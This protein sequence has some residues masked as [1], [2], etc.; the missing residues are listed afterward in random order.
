MS[1]SD[2]LVDA[3][4]AEAHIG[5]AWCRHRRGRRGHQRVR[6]GSHPQRDQDRL[7]EGPAGPGPPRLRRQDRLR[8]AA[9]R[10]GHLQRRHRAA[11]R[12]QQQLVRRLRV[13]VLQAVRPPERPAARRRP[14]EVG[15]RLARADHRRANPRED[16]LHRLRAGR[17]AARAARRGHRRD[18]Q[19]NLVD[20]RSPDEF[21]GR[22]LAP[23]HLPQEQAQRGGHI[24]TARTSRGPRP[25]TR[26]ARSGPTTSSPALPG[27]RRRW[28]SA[29]TP[30]PTAGSASARRTPGSC[31]TSCSACP[32]SRTTTARGP[33]TARWSACRS[34]WVRPDEPT[35]AARP[36][37]GSAITKARPA[38][39]RSSRGR[40][41]RAAPRSPPGT[42]G[43]SAPATSSWPR[44]RWVRRR[45]P[46]LR[47][48]RRRGRC[49]CS[50][51]AA[52]APSVRS[53]PTTAR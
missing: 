13:L 30:S 34:S 22:L 29:R 40:S 6:Q 42:P 32:T 38:A 12:R 49:A 43:C 51:R 3:D 47:R 18:R 39:R 15:A 7:E 27:A 21:T 50:P 24:P 1:R 19:A 25:R 23:A 53:R 52:C 45:L 41:P 5:D 2:V 35:A 10:A 16:Q 48:A 9:V 46:V 36:P 8:G 14:Q 33:S 28:T 26:T 11:L 20:V 17:L 44:S 4:W 37:A 31:C